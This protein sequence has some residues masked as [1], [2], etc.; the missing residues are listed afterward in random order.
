MLVLG[1]WRYRAERVIRIFLN[2]A[3]ARRLMS[4]L[5]DEQNEV[6]IER[7]SPDTVEFLK[8]RRDSSRTPE[9]IS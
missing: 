6:W 9:V 4:S 7:C 3:L 2:C 1:K 8:W 5:L